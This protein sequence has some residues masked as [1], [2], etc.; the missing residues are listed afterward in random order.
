M[1]MNS[2]PWHIE[3]WLG[4]CSSFLSELFVNHL[5][6]CFLLAQLLC[7]WNISIILH[8][9]SF[10]EIDPTMQ[11]P[12]PHMNLCTAL[13]L[14]GWGYIEVLIQAFQS[15]TSWIILQGRADPAQVCSHPVLSVQSPHLF[16]LFPSAYLWLQPQFP[17]ANLGNG[18]CWVQNPTLATCT[19]S[20][21]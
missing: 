8:S 13:A 7:Q 3:Y 10:P 12:V 5:L 17:Q 1:P 11:V 18:N 4:N 6:I 21:S 20:C 9:L 19:F 14:L 16:K 15:I 2:L